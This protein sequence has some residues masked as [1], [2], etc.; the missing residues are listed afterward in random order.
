MVG[1]K[2]VLVLTGKGLNK[3]CWFPHSFEVVI[4]LQS[5]LMIGDVLHENI[6][7]LTSKRLRVNYNPCRYLYSFF[8]LILENIE[9][10]SNIRMKYDGTPF[11]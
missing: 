8:K 10:L 3:L 4:R 7:A 11:K 9:P 6:S 1:D 5:H 2:N